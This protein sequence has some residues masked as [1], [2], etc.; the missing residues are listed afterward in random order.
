MKIPM[1]NTV[2]LGFVSI[3]RLIMELFSR[4][5]VGL[6]SLT[7]LF[8]KE[9]H[10]LRKS[11]MIMKTLLVLMDENDRNVV[12][13]IFALTVLDSDSTIP[14]AMVYMEEMVGVIMIM[15]EEMV[16]VEKATM[17]PLEI[18]PMIT[19]MVTVNLWPLVIYSS[20]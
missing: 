6:L 16:T 4:I 18:S 14:A 8:L 17:V 20:C 2:Q 19:V 15:L 3:F 11:Q 1:T 7:S 13:I 9:T 5:A 12:A 10:N